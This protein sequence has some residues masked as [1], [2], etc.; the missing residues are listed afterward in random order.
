MDK[1]KDGLS[2]VFF[3]ESI[4]I[5]GQGKMTGY[6]FVFAFFVTFFF[7]ER[8]DRLL[9]ELCI[10]FLQ[11]STEHSWVIY[12]VCVCVCV[13]VC[14]RESSSSSS[15]RG[16]IRQTELSVLEIFFKN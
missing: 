3:G 1:V 4:S 12:N 7:R 13:C 16:R 6:F 2:K 10:F 11:N 9:L 15:S 8:N 5:Y 14:E